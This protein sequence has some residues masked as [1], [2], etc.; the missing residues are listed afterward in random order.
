MHCNLLLHA[1][2]T[3][4]VGDILPCVLPLRAL[5][6][7]QPKRNQHNECILPCRGYLP[8]TGEE[9]VNTRGPDASAGPVEFDTGMGILPEAIDISGTSKTWPVPT[10]QA[11]TPE[12]TRLCICPRI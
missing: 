7:S 1:S 8:E 11:C 2:R 6:E 12:W 5:C 3:V 10:S 9:F 4:T